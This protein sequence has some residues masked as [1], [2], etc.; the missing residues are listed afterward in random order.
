MTDDKHSN[1]VTGVYVDGGGRKW[2]CVRREASM[3]CSSS[4]SCYTSAYFDTFKVWGWKLAKD[5]TY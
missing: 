2:F 1:L 3:D 5:Q 4:G